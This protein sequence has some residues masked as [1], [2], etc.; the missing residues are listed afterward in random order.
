MKGKI[1][2]WKWCLRKTVEALNVPKHIRAI[3]VNF[4]EEPMLEFFVGIM[5]A[6][7]TSVFILSLVYLESPN[8][9][10]LCFAF[11]P[12]IFLL[13]ALHGYYREETG[14]C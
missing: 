1:G 3:V 12:A 9:V 6:V 11:V 2:F 10:A 13:V 7:V 5:A 14:D 8:L 4:R